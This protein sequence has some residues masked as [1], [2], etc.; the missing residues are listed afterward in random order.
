MRNRRGNPACFFGCNSGCNFVF[1]GCNIDVLQ[2]DS[3]SA[4]HFVKSSET[5]AGVRKTRNPLQIK[6]SGFWWR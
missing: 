3:L 2:Y 6:D 1:F 5:A 4:V